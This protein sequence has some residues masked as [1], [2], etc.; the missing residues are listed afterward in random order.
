MEYNEENIKLLFFSPYVKIKQYC[1]KSIFYNCIFD[2]IIQIEGINDIIE[3]IK[4]GISLNNLKSAID[5]KFN[6]KESQKIIDKLIAYGV[7][8]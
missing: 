6:K 3:Q 2:T 8:E 7:I 4:E 5:A 1:N